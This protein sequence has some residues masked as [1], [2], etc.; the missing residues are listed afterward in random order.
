MGLSGGDA[1]ASCCGDVAGVVC[2][3]LSN[4]CSLAPAC[5]PAMVPGHAMQ[6]VQL[7]PSHLC[8]L[9]LP[10]ELLQLCCDH[11]LP[12]ADI[13]QLSVQLLVLCLSCSECCFGL[14]QMK[15]RNL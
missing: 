4:C 11:L 12:I 1:V 13:P 9:N 2:S 5:L 7:P 14:Q 15:H 10:V 8:R 3:F 6:R